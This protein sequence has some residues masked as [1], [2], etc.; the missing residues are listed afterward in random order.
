[1]LKKLITQDLDAPFLIATGKIPY[2]LCTVQHIHTESKLP[3]LLMTMQLQGAW[4]FAGGLHLDKGEAGTRQKHQAVRH[5]VHTRGNEFRAEAAG[6]F[7]C[8]D[9][10]LF[11][12]LFTHCKH[13]FHTR[14][15]RFM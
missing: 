9:K 4:L 7:H 13:P 10:A 11:D 15:S 1:M 3:Q 5:A 14:F 8:P 6:G 12:Y 2:F